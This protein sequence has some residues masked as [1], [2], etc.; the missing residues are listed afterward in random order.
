MI[1]LK[2]LQSVL[3]NVQNVMAGYSQDDTWSDYDREAHAKLI[4]MQYKVEAEINA[5]MEGNCTHPYLECGL[6]NVLNINGT[7]CIKCHTCGNENVCNE[8]L[9]ELPTEEDSSTTV[10]VGK[11]LK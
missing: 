10:S 9:L 8:D 1:N 3:H 2:E 11:K 4:D 5:N 6:S 7:P